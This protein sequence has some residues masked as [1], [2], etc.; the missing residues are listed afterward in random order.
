MLFLKILIFKSG[1]MAIGI[2]PIVVLITKKI[3]K[4]N[5]WYFC[6]CSFS[7]LC[8]TIFFRVLTF[9]SATPHPQDPRG[10]TAMPLAALRRNS[11]WSHS[12][13]GVRER[14][15]E[16]DRERNRLL[17]YWLTTTTASVAW[18]YRSREKKPPFEAPAEFRGPSLFG[19]GGGCTSYFFEHWQMKL[20][21]FRGLDLLLGFCAAATLV[22]DVGEKI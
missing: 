8:L 21:S 17:L 22:E 6:K 3:T 1:W 19:R 12:L 7:L 2:K 9:F 15:R 10:R 13:R 16:R 18:G 14:N 5:K 4:F 20:L 11:A